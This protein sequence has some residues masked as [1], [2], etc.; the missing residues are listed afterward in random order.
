MLWPLVGELFILPRAP[1]LRMCHTNRHPTAG[2]LVSRS[3]SNDTFA[4]G[5]NLQDDDLLALAD[6]KKHPMILVAQGNAGSHAVR[7]SDQHVAAGLAALG[8][9]T[10][11][12]Q[13]YRD[14]LFTPEDGDPHHTFKRSTR[15]PSRLA[16]GA[17]PNRLG[18]V[19][20]SL[21]AATSMTYIASMPPERSKCWSIF[22]P[23]RSN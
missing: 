8:Y 6:G 13:Y 22:R 14:D 1:A 17:D 21:G 11:V 2:G 19:G 12:P 4:S 5:A 23:D 20:Y 15:S 16:R 9:V 18:L 3:M 10:A 7:R